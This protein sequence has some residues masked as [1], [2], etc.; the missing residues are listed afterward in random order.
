MVFAIN[1]F[2]VGGRLTRTRTARV[3]IVFPVFLP[4]VVEFVVHS[5]RFVKPLRSPLPVE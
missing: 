4:D 1:R 2:Y 3:V 5:F